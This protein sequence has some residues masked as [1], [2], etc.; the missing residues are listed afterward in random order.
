MSWFVAVSLAR[1]L[2]AIGLVCDRPCLR[3]LSKGDRPLQQSEMGRVVCA[4]RAHTT[5]GFQ[6]SRSLQLI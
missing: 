3:S 6:P 5:K 2:F 1:S 4:R